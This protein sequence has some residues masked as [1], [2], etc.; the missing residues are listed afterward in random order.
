VASVKLEK[1]IKNDITMKKSFF[2]TAFLCRTGGACV[3]AISWDPGCIDDEMEYT[4]SMA[5]RNGLADSKLKH[6]PGNDSL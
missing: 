5:F 2:L 3:L 6:F 4:K 1:K